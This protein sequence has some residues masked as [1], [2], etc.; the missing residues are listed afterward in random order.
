MLLSFIV[1]LPSPES[2]PNSPSPV[3]VIAGDLDDV[4]FYNYKK[5]IV[6]QRLSAHKLR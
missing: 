2:N 4:I 3:V 6:L 1:Y 5:K